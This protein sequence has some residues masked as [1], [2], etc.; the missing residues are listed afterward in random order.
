M[1]ARKAV[2]WG[3]DLNPWPSKYVVGGLGSGPLHSR[4]LLYQ[5]N[6]RQPITSSLICCHSE[7][8]VAEQVN[9]DEG[10]M[11]RSLGT[12]SSLATARRMIGS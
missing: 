4:R 6:L 8:L 10:L 9:G 11:R 12:R 1:S 2:N 7:R 5:F 3:R